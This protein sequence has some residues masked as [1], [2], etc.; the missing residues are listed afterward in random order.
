VVGGRATELDDLRVSDLR[1]SARNPAGHILCFFSVGT[2]SKATSRL[3]AVTAASVAAAFPM[4][5]AVNEALS[6]PLK[7]SSIDQRK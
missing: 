1:L 4:D 6:S 2:E 5:H 3:P 7:S